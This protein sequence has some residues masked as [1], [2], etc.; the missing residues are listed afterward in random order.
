MASSI[1]TDFKCRANG[2]PLEGILDNILFTLYRAMYLSALCLKYVSVHVFVC[3]C[4]CLSVYVSVHVF[5]CL[6]LCLSVYVSVC[7]CVCL[8]MCLS[9]YVSVHVFVCLCLCLP[10]CVYVCHGNQVLHRCLFFP[11]TSW[12]GVVDQQTPQISMG[13]R[14]CIRTSQQRT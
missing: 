3:L 7:V 8:C 6:C 12:D 11:F 1:H 10:L 2:F 5:V 13:C 4:M 9:V 14:M